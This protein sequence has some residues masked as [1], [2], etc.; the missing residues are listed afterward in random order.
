MLK[1]VN[2][3]DGNSEDKKSEVILNAE[4]KQTKKARCSKGEI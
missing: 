1:T 4:I 3:Y 2:R